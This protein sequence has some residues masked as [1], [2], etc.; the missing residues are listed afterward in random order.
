MPSQKFKT[1]G[2]ITLPEDIADKPADLDTSPE[3]GTPG[4]TLE[5]EVN[6]P[7]ADTTTNETKPDDKKETTN[8]PAGGKDT[9]PTTEDK[10]DDKDKKTPVETKPDVVPA[11]TDDKSKEASSSSDKEPIDDKNIPFH[12]HPDWIKH[13]QKLAEIE[14]ENA[15]LKGRIDAK[16]APEEKPIK[17]ARE[18]MDEKVKSGWKAKDQVEVIETYEQFQQEE[19]RER[20]AIVESK[21]QEVA[22]QVEEVYKETGISDVE[23]QNKA[24]M[25]ASEWI[26]KGIANRSIETLKLAI[27]HLKAK[28][29]LSKP[30]PDT[31]TTTTTTVDAD[32]AAKDKTNS[33]ISKPAADGK[34][35]DTKPKR[36][37]RVERSQTL[38]DITRNLSKTL[39]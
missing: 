9:A 31:T 21:K 24:A 6:S 13:Q 15:Y 34:K 22:Q 35:P 39:G 2:E 8:A 5:T 28:G 10:P 4:V 17:T 16:P 1:L 30:A 20:Q 25:L 19:K 18:R 23:E 29:E 7:V 11:K 14:K 27:D 38:D 37:Y 33:R 26:R 36:D 3:G 32:K 12:K